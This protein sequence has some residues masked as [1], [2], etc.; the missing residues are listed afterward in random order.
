MQMYQYNEIGK[1]DQTR[2]NEPMCLL[3]AIGT[4]VLFK[5]LLLKNHFFIKR[6]FQMKYCNLLF[7]LFIV[8]IVCHIF[9]KIK[10]E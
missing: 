8:A 6:N 5:V 10:F 9:L 2:Y 7:I 4:M 3:N 1:G